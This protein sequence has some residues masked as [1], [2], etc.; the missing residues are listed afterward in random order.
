MRSSKTSVL[1]AQVNNIERFKGETKVNP[2]EFTAEEFAAFEKFK[3]DQSNERE[4]NL[5]QQRK[6]SGRLTSRVYNVNLSEDELQHAR[7]ISRRNGLR[8][9]YRLRYP[10]K[11]N[12]DIEK[13]V[14][15]YI[16][17]HPRTS[18]GK[19]KS[20]PPRGSTMK[21][22]AKE[23]TPESRNEDEN[24]DEDYDQPHSKGKHSGV[25]YLHIFLDQHPN[26]PKVDT[27]GELDKHVRYLYDRFRTDYK[28]ASQRYERQE[29]GENKFQT[30][31]RNRADKLEQQLRDPK[32]CV[33][34][35]KNDWLYSLGY[36]WECIQRSAKPKGLK[37]EITKEDVARMC[38][39]LCYYCGEDPG[40][41]GVT[42]GV[43][44]VDNSVGYTVE[45]SVTCCSV[46]NYAKKDLHVMDFI[47]AMCNVGH[48]SVC[49]DD[50]VNTY[51]VS[52]VFKLPNAS[53]KPVDFSGYRYAAHR[54][55]LQFNLNLKQFDQ[56]TS[57]VCYYC[58]R[59]DH[60][61][62]LDRVDS[63][64]NYEENTCV[65]CC[66][67]CNRLKGAN[68]VDIFLCKATMIY[69][70]WSPKVNK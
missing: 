48:M 43:D 47:Q 24:L 21:R 3:K 16:D 52:Y 66:S 68:D 54:R 53:Q 45:N 5:Y 59:S 28:E 9:N 64:N 35:V 27:R 62:G 8:H 12:D 51:N 63:V 69:S 11:T 58:E 50:K 56:M 26:I 29:D 70:L 17:D 2:K 31:L 67:I 32:S 23:I 25:N 38:V 6:A 55:G 46:C 22:K 15:K 57:N 41:T 33:P 20:G 44:R 13:M 37:I 39:Q 19:M 1:F 65:S 14:Q 34:D 10:D 61:M 18:D 7:D 4:R 30:W 60:K 36:R 42:F 49:E 40:E